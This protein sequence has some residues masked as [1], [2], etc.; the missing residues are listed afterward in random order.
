MIL[1]K[2]NYRRKFKTKKKTKNRSKEQQNI[3]N[4]IELF[5]LIIKS[6]KII[7]NE[8]TEIRKLLIL[9]TILKN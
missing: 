2:E 8:S 4:K 6:N 9:N 5:K 1:R 7:Q 3:Q